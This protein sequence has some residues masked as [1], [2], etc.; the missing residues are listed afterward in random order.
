MSSARPDVRK[1]VCIC[2][3]DNVRRTGWGGTGG[4]RDSRISQSMCRGYPSPPLPRSCTHNCSP[5]LHM[6]QI[7]QIASHY[8]TV[9]VAPWRATQVAVVSAVNT[10][11]VCGQPK[12]LRGGGGRREREKEKKRKM[13]GSAMCLWV[14]VCFKFLKE[15]FIVWETTIPPINYF[16]H[17]HRYKKKNKSNYFA[18]ETE[19]EG[20]CTAQRSITWRH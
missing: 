18:M 9:G 16:C 8:I 11:H 14:C 3:N 7:Q 10:A 5:S 15:Y 6:L 1:T 13:G 4:T 20:L 17:H 19:S 12:W 2:L